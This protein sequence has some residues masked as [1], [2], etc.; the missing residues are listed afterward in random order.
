MTELGQNNTIQPSEIVELLYDSLD[1]IS[2]SYQNVAEV[3]PMRTA[4]LTSD[5]MRIARSE[6]RNVPSADDEA[7]AAYIS[8]QQA[9]LTGSSSSTEPQTATVNTPHGPAHAHTLTVP[10]R[11]GVN[12]KSM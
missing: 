12:P 11:I 3:T 5:A 2:Y 7:F 10:K 6:G 4:D 8:H 9:S 1:A